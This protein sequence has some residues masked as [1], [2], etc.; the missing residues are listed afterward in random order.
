VYNIFAF[1]ITIIELLTLI[2]QFETPLS[3][4]ITSLRILQFIQIGATYSKDIAY[5]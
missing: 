1:L 2:F 5:A 4:F 3:E